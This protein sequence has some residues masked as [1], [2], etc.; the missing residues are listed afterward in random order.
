MIKTKPEEELKKSWKEDPRWK[1]IERPYTAE[2]VVRL[3]GSLR[4][5]H[6]LAE[7]GAKKLW[8]TFRDGTLCA[9]FRG[10]DGCAGRAASAGRLKRHLRQWLAGGRRFQ[11]C[12]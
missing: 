1:R 3:R 11:R 4:I 6:T 7:V 10:Y 5:A 8:Q 2:E 9:H 12:T